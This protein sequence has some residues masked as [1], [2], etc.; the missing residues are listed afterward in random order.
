MSSNPK[1]LLF[2]HVIWQVKNRDLL[3]TKPVR[4]VLFAH[5]KKHG[6][7]NGIRML[8][9]NGVEDHVHALLQLHAAQNLAQVMKSIRTNAADWINEG[10]FLQG[11]FEWQD[12]YAAYTVSPSNV[13]QVI[14]Y[15][16]KQEEHHKTKTLDS[17]LEVFRN[18]QF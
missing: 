3:L 6:E 17:E 12:D 5:I 9:V 14:D 18:I 10:R 11:H 15:I 7:E 16:N 4:T 1:L 13:K 2:I 8:A